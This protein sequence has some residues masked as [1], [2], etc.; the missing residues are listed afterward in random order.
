MPFSTTQERHCNMR[1]KRH[2]SC[3]PVHKF[4]RGRCIGVKMLSRC[5]GVSSALNWEPRL[6]FRHPGVRSLWDIT[7]QVWDHCVYILYVG[8]RLGRKVIVGAK[9][10]PR[11]EII[12]YTWD[13]SPSVRYLNSGEIPY[14]VRERWVSH[15]QLRKTPQQQPALEDRLPSEFH[16]WRLQQTG[17]VYSRRPALKSTFFEPLWNVSASSPVLWL[18]ARIERTK[19]LIRI[20]GAYTS[21]YNGNSLAGI[22]S[23]VHGFRHSERSDKM[24]LIRK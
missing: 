14:C 12:T 10:L 11:D 7:T 6:Q 1:I 23:V 16:E 20:R 9:T 18:N 5:Q 8:S 2:T 22:V 21:T 24:H 19:H 3:T 17:K 13:S 4:L 15:A